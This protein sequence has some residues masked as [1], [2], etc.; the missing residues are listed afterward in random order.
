MD[1]GPL[2]GACDSALSSV[3]K[4]KR[5]DVNSE[6]S[7][8]FEGK[9]GPPSPCLGAL[10]D[11][12]CQ[13][14]IPCACSNKLIP[15]NVFFFF[16]LL[17]LFPHSCYNVFSILTHSHPTFLPPYKLSD[18]WSFKN[19]KLNARLLQFACLSSFILHTSEEKTMLCIYS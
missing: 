15:E 9:K 11:P 13:E 4:M 6:N 17:S 5:A 1:L 8:L 18:E 14:T 10:L 3:V 16:P 19:Q 12:S 7:P 2:V